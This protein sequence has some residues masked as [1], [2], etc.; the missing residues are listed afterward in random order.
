M[1]PKT[2]T[3]DAAKLLASLKPER[4]VVY[5]SVGYRSSRFASRLMQEGVQLPDGGLYNLEGSIFKWANEGRPLV[6]NDR[7]VQE[8]HPYSWAWG[9]LLKSD[10]RAYTPH[11]GGEQT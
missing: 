2:S 11:D 9:K 4:V 1:N 10:L 5:C 3:S 7:P 8:V 6:C